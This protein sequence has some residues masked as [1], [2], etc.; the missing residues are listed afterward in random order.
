M[1]NHSIAR[2]MT[3][4]IF[5]K[6]CEVRMPQERRSLEC[7]LLKPGLCRPGSSLALLPAPRSGPDFARCWLRRLSCF[8]YPA[9][10]TPCVDTVYDE[11]SDNN[12]Q[13]A[14]CHGKKLHN[15]IRNDNLFHCLPLICCGTKSYFRTRK[16]IPISSASVGTYSRRG[17]SKCRC[18][19]M[20]AGQAFDLS[21]P[22]VSDS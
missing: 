3:F 7:P 6:S 9:S 15:R 14:G 17:S 18:A 13:N 11:T 1:A 19:G 4:T 8:Q 2:K 12:G 16:S 21:A 22:C 20:S 10:G 5:A